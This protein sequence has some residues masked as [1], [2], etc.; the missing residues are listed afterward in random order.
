MY[1][2]EFA[3][4]TQIIGP[5]PNWEQGKDGIFIGALPVCATRENGVPKIKSVWKPSAEELAT[6]VAGGCVTV[7]LID[8]ACAPLLVRAEMIEPKT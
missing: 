6:L 4:Q 3:D 1:A 7:T 2:I 8:S 5:P